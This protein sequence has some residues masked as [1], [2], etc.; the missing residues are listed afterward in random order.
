MRFDWYSATIRQRPD[1]VLAGIREALKGDITGSEAQSPPPNYQAA[2]VLT[3]ALGG[4]VCVVIYG[5][6]N[7]VHGTHVRSSGGY[8]PVVAHTLRSLWPGHSLTRADVAIDLDGPG[9]F[10]KLYGV[11]DQVASDRGLKWSTIGDFR[12]NRDPLSGRTIMLGA[13]KDTVCH[14]RVYEKGK[15]MIPL[16]RVGDPPP[17]LDWCRVELEVKPQRR[18]A[19]LA[20][21]MFS[22]EQFWG[23]STW[24]PILLKGVCGL[25]VERVN[26]SRHRESDAMRS[27][28]HMAM[29]YR[30]VIEQ[31][32]Q[33][34]GGSDEAV[35]RLV[36]QIWKEADE[37][38]Q[39]A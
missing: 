9:C 24:T 1:S 5:G 22:V 17:S 25:D 21:S 32:R 8:S 36:K 31:V 23:A 14:L 7:G 10:D 11:C 38:T 12:E 16:L 28:R 39:V 18:P 19:R 2:E 15:Q 29:Q 30:Q 13:R 26:M 33:E 37:F 4:R 27:F 20:A 3:D 35:M 6:P 34:Q